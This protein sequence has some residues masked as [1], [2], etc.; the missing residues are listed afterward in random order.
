MIW[1]VTYRSGVVSY[2]SVW[3]SRGMYKE[4]ALVAVR[5]SRAVLLDGRGRGR[6]AGGGETGRRGDG[7]TGR[8]EA[9][10]PTSCHPL[11]RHIGT[12]RMTYVAGLCCHVG[13]DITRQVRLADH[14]RPPGFGGPSLI[15]VMLAVA[16]GRGRC[17]SV[18]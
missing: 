10:S 11:D 16:V 3:Q 7:E 17:L 9:A 8:R 18:Q 4:L 15:A 6:E 1:H 13:P 2:V 12:C 5:G 14:P